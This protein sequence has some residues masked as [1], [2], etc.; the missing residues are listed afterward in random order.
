MLKTVL[1]IKNNVCKLESSKEQHLFEIEAFCNI[2]TV[3]TATFDQFNAYWLNKRINKNT[4]ILLTWAALSK[5]IVNLS[6][7]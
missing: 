7:S 4:N 5:S 6:W 1:V 2:I 3:F